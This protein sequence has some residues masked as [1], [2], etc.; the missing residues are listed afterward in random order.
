M[1]AAG[2]GIP[3]PCY[4]RPEGKRNLL[5]YLEVTGRR[6]LYTLASLV[7]LPPMSHSAT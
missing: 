2:R 5:V 4:G 3:Q 7:N 1:T 6:R